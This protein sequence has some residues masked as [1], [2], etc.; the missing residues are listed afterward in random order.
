M[1][2]RSLGWRTDLIFPRFEGEIVDRGDYLVIRTPSN[3]TF[4]WGN[5]L[6]FADPPGAGDLPRWKQIFRDEIAA[7]EPSARHFAF[8]W[9]RTDGEAGAAR[10]FLEDGFHLNRTVVLTAGAMRRPARHNDEVVI[11]PLAT[12]DEW[13][14]ALENQVAYREDGHS[15]A[16]WRA[17]KGPQMAR[18]RRMADAGRGWWFGAFLADRLVADLGIFRDE[19]APLA[20]FQSVGTHPDFRRRGICGALVYLAAQ[21]ALARMNVATLVMLA[22]EAYHAARIYESVGFRPTE[23]IVGTEWRRREDG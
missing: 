9:D 13:R 10:P 14:Q 18:Y 5:F 2:V 22:D 12:D 11:R 23:H 21:Y 4:W 3:P 8:G 6:L 1:N 15:E 7:R 20:R 17:Y 19:A 16:G